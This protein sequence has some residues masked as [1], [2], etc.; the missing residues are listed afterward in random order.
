M[1]KNTH[2]SKALEIIY[3]FFVGILVAVFVGVGIAAFYPEPKE[4]EYPAMLKVYNAPIESGK[5][6]TTSAELLVEQKK[7]DNEMKA[8]QNEFS[9]Y[10]RNVSIIALISAIILLTIS[11]TFF[12][13]LLVIADGLLLGGV[14]TL[15]YSVARI[16]GSGDDKLRF[17]VVSVGL[18]FALILGYKKFIGQSKDLT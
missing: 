6:S 11:I 9:I 14:I 8:F 18:A 10:N 1:E 12:K 5:A 4:P 3:T 16:F 17:L 2:H 13:N 7:Y 15:L